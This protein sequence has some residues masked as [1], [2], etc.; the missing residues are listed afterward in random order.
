MTSAPKQDSW[1]V[2]AL[3]GGAVR[4]FR[5]DHTSAIAKQPL[6]GPVFIHR[7]G[8]TGDSQADRSVHGGPE[9]AVHCY[10]L[11]HHDAWRD[12]LGEHPLLDDPGAFGSNLAIRGLSEGDVHIGDRFRLGSALLELCQPRQPCWKVEHHFDHKWMVAHIVLR[13]NCGFYFRVL[14]EGEAQA[15]DRLERV[16][17]GHADW[18]VSRMFAANYGPDGKPSPAL[19]EEM[20][21][22]ERIAE[23]LR[24][25]IRRKFL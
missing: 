18:P 13:G 23:E 6:T 21:G 20:L 24:A 15:G 4:P 9:K 3:L 22:L 14:E 10:P 17:V 19:I 12:V 5:G 16:E 25:R 2:E 8:L 7:E 1:R 11:D